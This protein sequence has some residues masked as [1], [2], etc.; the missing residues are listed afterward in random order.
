MPAAA[1]PD[2]SILQFC[3]SDQRERLQ[4]WIDL[5]TSAKAAAAYNEKYGTRIK[6]SAFVECKSNAMA[7]A[8]KA[9]WTP[10]LDASRM[11][12]PTEQVHGRS[13]LTK[14]EDG[15]SVWLKT[16]E[17]KDVDALKATLDEISS[18]LKPFKR[19]SPPSGVD[20]ELIVVYTITDYHIG[21]Y[22][23]A[24]ETGADWD[25]DIAEAVLMGAVSD[26]MEGSPDSREA[27]FCQLGDF[28]HWD[29]LVAVT[30]TAKNVLDADT[31]YPL[32]VKLA[33]KCCLRA[34]EMLLHKHEIV[35]VKMCEGNHDLA[36][37]VWLQQLM[38]VM[39]QDNPRVR[40]DDSSFPYYYH[41]FGENFIGWHHGHLSKIRQMPAKFWSE[42]GAIMGPC[43]Y[44]YLHTGHL[45]T[46]EVIEAAG[47]VVERHPTL[48]A[49]DAHGARGFDQT[50]RA[51][52]TITY[53][54][55]GGERSRNIVYPR[56]VYA[57]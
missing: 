26:M 51:A 29:G 46:K 47:V 22:S 30:P 39:F 28:L 7:R 53:Q 3:T 52:Q 34:V 16:R 8:A 49:R 6:A 18:G 33:I 25:V 35:H 23:W 45:H 44:R 19:V 56:A 2:P 9:G 12:P 40:V 14:D 42:F 32:L 11:V 4:L 36:G 21:A 20:D 24:P 54:I 15:N 13:I 43:K 5:G 55:Q 10:N 1:P 41:V 31:R 50:I 48:N 37:S 57:P 27:V 38:V 17:R